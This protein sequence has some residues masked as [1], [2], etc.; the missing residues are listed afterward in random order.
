M[1]TVSARR[2]VQH[3]VATSLEQSQQRM[4]GLAN[5]HRRDVSF[6]QG[7][8]VW[9]STGNLPLRLGSRK[10]AAKWAGPF[11][12]TDVVAPQAYR[13]RLPDSW[14]IHDVFHAS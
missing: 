14:R 5:P 11:L 2:S 10:L 3:Q 6:Q 7:D 13:L 4:K 9:L 8:R 12:V 1:D